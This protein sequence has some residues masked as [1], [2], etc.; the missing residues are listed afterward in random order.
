MLRVVANTGMGTDIPLVVRA[1]T[2]DI[3]PHVDMSAGP[4]LGTVEHYAIPFH[5]GA[6]GLFLFA[7]ILPRIRSNLAIRR[8]CLGPVGGKVRVAAKPAGPAHR[9]GRRPGARQ[10]AR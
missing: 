10:T 6:L 1:S 7:W 3:D 5:N 2:G 8:P 4:V 9:A